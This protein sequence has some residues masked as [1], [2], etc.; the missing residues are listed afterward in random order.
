[1]VFTSLR[2]KKSEALSLL[3]VFDSTN[4]FKLPNINNLITV[5]KTPISENFMVDVGTQ[6]VEAIKT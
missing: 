2:T 6:S 3:Y 1:M 5:T 4:L